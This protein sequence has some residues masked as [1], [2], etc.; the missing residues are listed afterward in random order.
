MKYNPDL[1]K[2]QSIRL[3]GYDYSQSGFY[4]ITIC[5]YQRKCL[6]GNIIDSQVELNNLGEL[7]KE[8]WVKSAI[9]LYLGKMINYILIILL[10]GN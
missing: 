3:R 9:I 7:V 2:R 10:N 8:E 5:C 4:F 1:H 6:F